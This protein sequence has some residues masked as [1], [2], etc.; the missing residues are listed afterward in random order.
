[1]IKLTAIKDVYPSSKEKVH[2][3]IQIQSGFTWAE[4]HGEEVGKLPPT[5]SSLAFSA[6]LLFVRLVTGPGLWKLHVGLQVNTMA[7]ESGLGLDAPD[8][9]FL[10]DSLHFALQ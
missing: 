10:L 5:L 9:N 2:F 1:M 6:R 4:W 3:L 7:W 8:R